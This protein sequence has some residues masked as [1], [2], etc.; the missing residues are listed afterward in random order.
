MAQ[1]L[2]V[3]IP[4][5]L[6]ARLAPL[7]E[8]MN[9]SRVC[10]DALREEAD[11]LEG[12][13]IIADP[14]VEKLLSRLR[15]TSEQWYQFGR[16]DGEQWAIEEAKR[17]QLRAVATGQGDAPPIQYELGLM[18][19]TGSSHT[20]ESKMMDADQEAYAK[21]WRDAVKELWE[22]VAPALNPR[23]EARLLLPLREYTPE[24]QKE[25]IKQAMRLEGRAFVP[26]GGAAAKALADLE[27]D[28]WSFEHRRAD[29]GREYAYVVHQGK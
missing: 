29:D 23:R 8:R 11:M 24:Q 26:R 5:D 1:K 27:R 12:A 2:T 25:Q 22:A 10:A 17:D 4:D 16:E 14:R 18:K 21:G 7:R 19:R 20:S 6:Y 3:T 13:P 15:T 9:I 28:G